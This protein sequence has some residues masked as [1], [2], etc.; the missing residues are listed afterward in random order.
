MSDRQWYEQYQAEIHSSQAGK[1]VEQIED[2]LSK[3]AEYVFN[4]DTVQ[5]VAHNW[6]KRGI[7]LSCE[8]AG[9]KH[10]EVW[11]RRQPIAE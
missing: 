5:P 2:M 11:I 10:H 4:P 1:P 7:K 8:G 6:V 9:H 3:Q